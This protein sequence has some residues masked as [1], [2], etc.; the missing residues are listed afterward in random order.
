VKEFLV[1]DYCLY[2]GSGWWKYEFCYGKK[3]EQYHQEGKVRK[4]VI[5]LGNF[6]KEKHL[7]W[8]KANPAKRP[9]P[10]EARK[11]VSHF[12]SGGDLCDLTRKLYVNGDDAMF[13][14]HLRNVF[15]FRKAAPG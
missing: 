3:V 6:D 5:S 1:G 9:K 13:C 2:G 8:L 11:H 7:E 14:R 4:T 12:Y 10:V 15:L